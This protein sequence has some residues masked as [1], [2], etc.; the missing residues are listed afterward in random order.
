MQKCKFCWELTVNTI[1]SFGY[2]CCGKLKCLVKSKEFNKQQKI[3]SSLDKKNNDK[4][5]NLMFTLSELWV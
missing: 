5:N 4:V 1:N 3:L 2:T